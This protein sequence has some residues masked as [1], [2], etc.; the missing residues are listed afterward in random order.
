MIKFC[1]KCDAETERNKCGGCKP[2]K[3]AR[4]TAN[5]DK[6]LARNAAYYAANREKVLAAASAWRAANRDKAIAR[7]AAW[8]AANREK[9]LAASSAWHAA[10]RDKVRAARSAYYAENREKERAASLA[11]YAANREKGRAARS[12]WHAANPEKCRIY[13]QN[14]KARKRA[15]GGKLSSN[16]SA[17]LFKLQRGKCTCCG[18][19]LGDDFHLDHIV[20]LALGGSNTD[21]NIQLL[22]QRC[23]NQ[24]HAQ[25]PVDFM[26]S[27]GFLL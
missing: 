17:K 15:N 27:R 6:V 13:N 11:W 2:C 14:R 9:V 12:V 8:R 25:H 10:N 23:N 18:Q 20:P 3:A 16:L 22:R 4:Y 1:N 24:K 19:P 5:R 21:D 26:Q 7:C